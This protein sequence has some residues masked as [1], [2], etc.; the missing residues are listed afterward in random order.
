MVAAAPSEERA[1]QIRRELRSANLPVEIRVDKSDAIIR[2]ADLVLTKSGTAVLQVARHGKPMVVM[3]VVPWWQWIFA[4]ILLTIPHVGMINI[5]AGR[6]VVPEFVPARSPLRVARVCIDL[7]SQPELGS[8]MQRDMR[9]VVETLLP[10]D[11]KLAA[12]RVAEEVATLTERGAGG[13]D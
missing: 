13:V 6:E 5:L 8:I 3:F 11:G 9:A 1:W 2:W 7:L 10:R 12:D 4:R